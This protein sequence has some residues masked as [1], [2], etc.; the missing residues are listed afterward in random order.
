M[1]RAVV[2]LVRKGGD[3]YLDECIASV[4]AS[5]NPHIIQECG[6]EWGQ[7][8]YQMKDIADSVAWVDSDDYV[9]P[10]VMNKAFELMEETQVGV[11][12]T[13]EELVRDGKIL[14]KRTGSKSVD[15]FRKA[16]FAIHHLA[17]TRKG[18]VSER[19]LKCI[20]QMHTVYDWPIRLD[21]AV[22]FG[23]KHLP[24]VGYVWRRHKE[25]ETQSINRAKY[26]HSS[27]EVVRK[28]YAV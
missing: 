21:A 26:L 7:V 8:L 18:A 2:T 13:D 12:Y 1:K 6:D 20:N 4:R 16:P 17:I 24:K 10:E 14:F 9:Y 3:P 23:T 19:A 28:E 11:V 22:N 27:L 25:Q 15:E 5:G